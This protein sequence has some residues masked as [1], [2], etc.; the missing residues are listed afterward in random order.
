MN[1]RAPGKSLQVGWQSPVYDHIQHGTELQGNHRTPHTR[2]IRET[3]FPRFGFSPV[4]LGRV[5]KRQE[6]AHTGPFPWSGE[7]SRDL[8][9]PGCCH[10]AKASYWWGLASNRWDWPSGWRVSLIRK[11]LSLKEW[12]TRVCHSCCVTLGKTTL[13]VNFATGFIL[14]LFPLCD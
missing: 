3:C 5:Q 2:E 10:E 7:R 6:S 12:V 13:A 14:C 9:G 8:Q 11:Q 4:I 1:W